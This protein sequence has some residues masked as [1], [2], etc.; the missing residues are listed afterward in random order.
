MRVAA[1]VV[2]MVG[3][4]NGGGGLKVLRHSLF[5]DLQTRNQSIQSDSVILI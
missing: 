1:Q 3:G 5:Q 4:D 2:V